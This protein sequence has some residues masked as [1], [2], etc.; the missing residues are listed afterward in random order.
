MRRVIITLAIIAGSLAGCASITTD[1]NRAQREDSVAA[2]KSFI[3]NHPNSE[4]IGHAQAK[5]DSLH[6]E[7]V[8]E[9]KEQAE[10]A[11]IIR[12]LGSELRSK[13]QSYEIGQTTEDDFLSDGWS[14]EALF[15]G[16][17]GILEADLD[18]TS[19]TYT[20]GTVSLSADDPKAGSL[21]EAQFG[22]ACK[23]RNDG[24]KVTLASTLDYWKVG[25]QVDRNTRMGL[26]GGSESYQSFSGLETSN[27]TASISNRR[28]DRRV[29]LNTLYCSPALKSKEI[30]PEFILTFESNLLKAIN[31]SDN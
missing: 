10:K 26:G 24:F 30:A 16:Q 5:I 23:L 18:S 9:A 14:S 21:F 19:S 4:Y 25:R 17:I 31:R 1:W 29:Y 7:E 2:Y 6:A 3:A 15:Y 11:E 12:Q 20:L 13:I 28:T 8:R 22:A 27:G